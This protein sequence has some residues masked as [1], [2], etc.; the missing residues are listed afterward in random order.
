MRFIDLQLRFIVKK[1]KESS[2]NSVFDNIKG[3]GPTRIKKIWEVYDSVEQIKKD[4]IDNIYK[5][6]KFPMNVVRLLKN[7]KI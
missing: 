5:K 3:M 6:T 1:E 2:F 4:S 7:I